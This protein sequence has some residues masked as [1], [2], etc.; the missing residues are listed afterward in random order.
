MLRSN[1]HQ[2]LERRFDIEPAYQQMTCHG[3]KHNTAATAAVYTDRYL[4]GQ[5]WSSRVLKWNQEQYREPS[6]KLGYRFLYDKDVPRKYPT[7]GLFN[8]VHA[9]AGEASVR[10]MP[11]RAKF[12]TTA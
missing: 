11:V 5:P 12:N 8:Q 2:P 3:A 10:T 4:G 1:G 9:S 7:A 6:N